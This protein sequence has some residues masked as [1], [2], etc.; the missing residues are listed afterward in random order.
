MRSVMKYFANTS[1]A[2]CMAL[3]F[4]FTSV[5]HAETN[6][7]IENLSEPYKTLNYF[8]IFQG[9]ENGMLNIDKN[10][11]RAEMCKVMCCTMNIDT[12]DSLPVNVLMFRD[13]NT[14]DWFYNYVHQAYSLNL[15]CG[16]DKGY[17]EPN[18]NILYRDVIK[19]IVT[20]LGYADL[21][22]NN[23]GY[24]NGYIDVASELGLTK[25]LLICDMESAVRGDVAII[26]NN[27]LDV[28]LMEEGFI[29]DGN[30]GYP[31]KTF[32]YMLEMQF[33]NKY[34]TGKK[35]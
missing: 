33:S 18:A 16:N 9:D 28:P 30:N 31:Y 6:I 11:T 29:M 8:K 22:E 17:F 35:N 20:A 26:I 13:V 23:G 14:T 24:P 10:I 7:P 1:I 32:R 34:F 19:I 12:S 5:A 27:A 4:L 15:I 3:I 25:D 2:L 21:A